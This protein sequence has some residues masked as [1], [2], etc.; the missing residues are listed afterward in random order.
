VIENRS[1]P[2]S[3]VIP[4]LA[5]ADVVEATDWLCNAFGFTVR[6]RIGDHRA[7]LV[8]DDG[9]VIVTKLSAATG[10]PSATHSVHVQ[11]EDA[12]AT[13]NRPRSSARRS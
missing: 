2:A 5:Y 11:V 13:T 8:Y 4:V 9:A 7:Q 12:D 10:D 6:L 3:S 1:V